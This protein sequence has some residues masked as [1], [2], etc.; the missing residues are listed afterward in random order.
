MIAVDPIL[1]F[2]NI[3]VWTGVLEGEQPVSVVIVADSSSGKSAMLQKLQCPITIFQTDMTTRDL[4]EIMKDKDKRI[5]LLSDMQ[6]IFSHKSTVVGTT[7]QALRNLLEEGIWNDPFTGAS[8][9][10]RFGMISGIPPVEFNRVN[11]IF[12]S[13]G[14]DTRFLVFQ[15]TYKKGTISAIHD[16]IEHGRD[17]NPKEHEPMV[18]LPEDGEFRK[19]RL[20]RSIARKCRN[21]AAALKRDD[22]GLRVHHQIRRLVMA[23]AARAGR[24][25]AA[26]KDYELIES[27][28]DFLDPRLEQKVS[29]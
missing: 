3:C 22:I 29:I 17:A 15:Y 2:L 13:G 4:S 28:S 18:N 5:I 16:F 1:D 24:R 11:K 26:L 6:A 8:A 21:L 12:V 25:Q 20:S 14:L 23:A 19:V 7:T 9:K 10:R 27:Y